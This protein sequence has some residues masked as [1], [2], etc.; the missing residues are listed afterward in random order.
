MTI[1]GLSP[2]G[3]DPLGDGSHPTTR[4]PVAEIPLF[5]GFETHDPSGPTMAM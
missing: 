4:I 1:M 2:I 5:D 3:G